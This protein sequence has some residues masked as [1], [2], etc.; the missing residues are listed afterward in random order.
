MPEKNNVIFNPEKGNILLI[1]DEE[2][3]YHL[4]KLYLKGCYNLDYTYNKDDTMIFLSEK[5]YLAILLDINLGNGNSGIDILTLIKNLKNKN[6]PVIAVTANT[7]KQ[8]VETY[9]KS[10]FD[11]FLAKPYS[12]K[13]LETVLSKVVL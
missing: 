12:K 4:T 8:D 7:L 1:D 11:S 2:E 3:N 5:N 9:M 13:E 6:I 10:G